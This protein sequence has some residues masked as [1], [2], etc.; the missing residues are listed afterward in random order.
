VP[1]DR[2]IIQNQMFRYYSLYTLETCKRISRTHLLNIIAPMQTQLYRSV[3]II[4]HYTVAQWR[5]HGKVGG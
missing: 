5:S 2:S 3:H 4:I 1:S